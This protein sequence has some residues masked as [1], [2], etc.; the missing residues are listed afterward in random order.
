M[1]PGARAQIPQIL[2]PP[3][4]LT[5]P[6]TFTASFSVAGINATGYQWF[7]Q[8]NAIIGATNDV[9]NVFNAQ[10][11][12]AGSYFVMVTNT[13]S[14]MS[15]DSVSA[16]LTVTNVPIQAPSLQLATLA[17]LAPALDGA[18]PQSGLIQ[19]SDGYLYGTALKGGGGDLNTSS[20][21]LFK[22]S[23][24]GSL[25]W[26]FAFNGADSQYPVGA[27]SRQATEIST[28]SPPP[29]SQRRLGASS[30]S[31]PPASL[32]TFIRSPTAPT[33][34]I[35]RPAYAPGA[36]A[37]YTGTTTSGS[38]PTAARFSNQPANGALLRRLPADRQQQLIASAILT[39]A[40]DG[41]FYGTASSGRASAMLR[42][43]GQ[44]Q[45]HRRRVFKPL[46]L[47]RRKR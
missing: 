38:R 32:P 5:V 29:A 2:V 22:M 27:W 47:E 45:L 42:E 19:A 31:P 17:S 21:T 34:P 39:P 25:V 43:P 8:S 16:T 24:N 14:M 4:S 11:S 30:K 46:L 28:A 41:N 33:A 1:A 23:T 7:F 44:N 26:P 37:I 35:P 18:F 36:T 6:T 15:T 3:Q 12:N 20:G 10:P 13:S 9:L 40:P